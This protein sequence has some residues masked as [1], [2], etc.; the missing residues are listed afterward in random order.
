MKWLKYSVQ[1]VVTISVFFGTLILPIIDTVR[2]VPTELSVA[3]TSSWAWMGLPADQNVSSGASTTSTLGFIHLNCD[4]WG[5]CASGMYNTYPNVTIDVETGDVDGFAWVGNA[6]ADSGT[7][8]SVGWLNFDPDP[9]VDATYADASCTA[10]NFFPAPPC[11]AAQIDTSNQQEIS[12][13]AR[14]ET[15][16]AY[17]DTVLGTTGKNNDW[18]WVLLRGT[19]TAD[20]DEFGLTYTGESI[21]GWAWSGGGTLPSASFSNAVGFGWLNFSSAGSGTATGP[22]TGYISTEQG[23]VYGQSGISNPGGTLSPSQYNA[24]YL[25]LSSNSSAIANFNSELLGDGN[26]T[27]TDWGEIN[28]PDETNNYTSELGSL[29]LTKL[30][31]VYAAGRNVYNNT[32]NTLSDMSSFAGDEFL[33]GEVYVIGATCCTGSYT[34]NDTVTFTNGTALPSTGSNFDGSGV[35]VVNGDLTINANLYYNNTALLDI[36]NLASVAWIVR[37]D[38]TIGENVAQLVGSFFVLGDTAIGDGLHDGT[39]TTLETNAQQLSVYGMVMARAFSLNRSYGGT[40]GSD[41]PAEVFYYDG[42]ILAH[43]PPGLREYASLL[44]LISSE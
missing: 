41:E 2:A 4:S 24:T 17:G 36:Q 3:D 18:G 34:I 39:F 23:N 12:G 29:D 8:Y 40:S 33:D 43:T 20:G 31:T 26:F 37:G 25:L 5:T 30:T 1:A 27:A 28:L 13:W 9:L 42:R 6:Q 21:E 38:L 35:I 7:A 44:P 22:T 14:F 10:P 32:V 19:N 15:L 16:A 11:H